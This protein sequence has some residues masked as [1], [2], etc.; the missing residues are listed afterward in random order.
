MSNFFHIILDV[1]IALAIVS[2]VFLSNLFIYLIKF[3]FYV[4]NKIKDKFGYKPIHKKYMWKCPYCGHNVNTNYIKDIQ[5][6]NCNKIFD[7]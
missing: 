6:V 4:I 7:V 5:C 1:I 2:F 3:Y